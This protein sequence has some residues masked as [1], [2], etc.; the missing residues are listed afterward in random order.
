M[1]YSE[2]VERLG[3]HVAEADRIKARSKRMQEL[4]QM[5]RQGKQEEAKRE[6]ANMDRQPHVTDAGNYFEDLKSAIALLKRYNKFRDQVAFV[7]NHMPL[8][9]R[10]YDALCEMIE[11][12][13]SDE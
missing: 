8:D 7:V 6:L 13:G 2:V 12:V 9:D 1:K 4:A 3:R 10:T 5:A 11:K